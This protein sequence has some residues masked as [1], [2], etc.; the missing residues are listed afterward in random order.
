MNK[1]NLIVGQI[2]WVIVGGF[3]SKDKAVSHKTTIESIGRKYFT[4]SYDSRYKFDLGTLKCIETGRFIVCLDI[5]IYNQELELENY[6][7]ILLGALNWSSIKNYT[8]EQLK[9]VIET[10]NIEVK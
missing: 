10:L 5:E 1:H 8:I 7:G 2:V 3:R 6:R 4:I 9:Q